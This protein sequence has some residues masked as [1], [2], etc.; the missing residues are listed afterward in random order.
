MHLV[1]HPSDEPNQ[2]EQELTT[3]DN[4]LNKLVFEFEE[5]DLSTMALT[6]GEQNLNA[7]NGNSAEK[8]EYLMKQEDAKYILKWHFGVK[9]FRAWIEG[10]NGPLRQRLLQRKFRLFHSYKLLVN[11]RLIYQKIKHWNN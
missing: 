3:G 5:F 2:V 10:K 11:E 9:L 1:S 4:V 8:I 6:G 7:T